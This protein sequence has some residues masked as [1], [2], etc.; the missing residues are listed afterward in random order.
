M[1]VTR[2]SGKHGTGF[3]TI[4]ILLICQSG[5]KNSCLLLLPSTIPLMEKAGLGIFSKG[6]WTMKSMSA[7]GSQADPGTLLMVTSIRV[8]K[9]VISGA[10]NF[11]IAKS[12]S[13]LVSDFSFPA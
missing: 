9:S 13:T 8:G 6:G 11:S 4:R 12:T 10:E 3:P 2:P 1:A 7:F 5:G